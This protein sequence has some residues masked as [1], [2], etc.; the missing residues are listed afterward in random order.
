MRRFSVAIPALITSVCLY[1]IFFFGRDA[2][3]I[4][5]S[6]IWGLE[7]HAFA[8]AVYDI[9]QVLNLGAGGV[10]RVAGFLAG[11]KLAV[12]VAFTLHLADRVNP[13][14]KGGIDHEMLD[15]AALLAIV[16]TIPV[17]LPAL[18]E[19]TPQLLAP[20]RPAFWLAGLAATLSMIERVAESESVAGA[21]A[22]VKVVPA[23][24]PRRGH[25]SAL[26]WDYLRREANGL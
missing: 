6:P 12:A 15:A 14:R 26:R 18:L 4:L 2:V 11:L 1:F 17:A 10:I 23:L 8:R 16:A 19:A 21:L 7:D 22:P 3:S 5:S 9:A 25:A 24:P 20:H 13:Y